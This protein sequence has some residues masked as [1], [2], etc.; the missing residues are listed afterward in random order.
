V[1]RV[2]GFTDEELAE[3]HAKLV[4]ISSLYDYEFLNA[5]EVLEACQRGDVDG[6]VNLASDGEPESWV[7]P[8]G[9]VDRF[10]EEG[11]KRHYAEQAI[12]EAAAGPTVQTEL[13]AVK[14]AIGLL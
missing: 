4:P 8:Q 10:Y 11:I 14:G 1:S 12:R 6:A 2:W 5:F 9:A 3:I 7:L 13:D